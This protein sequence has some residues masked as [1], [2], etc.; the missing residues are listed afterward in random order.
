[1]I[2]KSATL[3]LA[4]A[5][6]VA[7]P[8]L[9]YADNLITDS[10]ALLTGAQNSITLSAT[11]GEQKN[12]NVV[13]FI[14]CATQQHMAGTTT[15]SYSTASTVP[16]GGSMSAT[17]VAITKPTNWPADGTACAKNN[18]E[19]TSVQDSA[20]TL[21]AP[22]TD[23]SY[24]YS[25]KYTASDA[26]VNDTG[27][28]AR[29]DI[30]VN[31]ATPV[32]SDS[33][34]PVISKQVTGTAGTNDWYTSNVSV[35]WSVSDPESSVTTQG[36][37]VQS[38][39][40]NTAAQAS[41]CS[42]TSAGGTSSQSV[43]LKIDKDAP[44]ATGTPRTTG[45][46][47]AG[48][49]RDDVVVDWSCSDVGPSGLVTT[50][51]TTSSV[52]GE[53]RGRTSSIGTVSDAAG[54]TTTGTSGAVDIDRNGPTVG[55]A[56]QSTVAYT[57]SADLNWYKDTA[58]FDWS[59]SD[60]NLADLSFGSGVKAGSLSPTSHTFGE[61]FNQSSSASASD[62]ADNPGSGSLTGVNVDASAPT[63]S[64]AI[65]STSPYNDG[66][67]AW[68]KDSVAIKVTA[69]DPALSD[70]H[71]GSG[72]AA[73]PSGT[74]TKTTSGSYSA[75]A[76]D[77]VGHSTTSDSVS[78]KVDA[79][80]PTASLTCP[81]GTVTKGAAATASWTASDEQGGSG[82]AGAATGTVSLDTSSVGTKTASLPAGTAKDNVGH[83]SAVATCSYSVIYDWTGFFQPIDNNPDQSGALA[84]A[85]VWNSAK[86]GSAIPVKFSLGGDQGLD[87]FQS[88]PTSPSALK[89]TCPGSSVLVDAIEEL[90]TATTSGLKYDSISQQYNYTWKTGTALAN[91][92]QRLTVT[93]KDGTSHYAFFKFTK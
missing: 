87:I 86:A 80:A 8:S 30:T 56:G 29:V 19:S 55:S 34:P 78:Y 63:A 88:T 49:Y 37:G 92:C 48:W 17:N 82:L 68:Y 66:T 6:V 91:T 2:K 72:L 60:P 58:A 36:C 21:T 89:V 27:Q 1:M 20:V 42:A 61:G 93:L 57:D 64:A 14:Q 83:D 9:G 53:G 69:S 28:N 67:N 33:T 23:G 73:D 54:N 52:T 74:V 70:S 24:I 25:L 62:N 84:L 15:V 40:S 59:A 32:P 26:D 12:F 43:N 51:P 11:P 7:A 4:L 76:T 75:T 50:C 71:A 77:N 85:T 81:T 35:A 10:D 39:T 65:T 5:G 79:T 31:V 13:L 16:T 22:S 47:A 46:S 41:S 38:F 18:P 44:T 3:A 45:K 90:G